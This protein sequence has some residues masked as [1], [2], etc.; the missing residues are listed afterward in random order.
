MRYTMQKRVTHECKNILSSAK[1]CLSMQELCY[2]TL[3]SVI[4][5]KKC[6]IQGNKRDILQEKQTEQNFHSFAI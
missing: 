5:C 6:A 3:K 1:T 4:Q 2:P